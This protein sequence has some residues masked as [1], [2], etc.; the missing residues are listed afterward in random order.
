M[1][2]QFATQSL[3]AWNEADL[4]YVSVRNSGNVTATVETFARYSLGIKEAAKSLGAYQA[5]DEKITFGF[6]ELAFDPKPGDLVTPSGLSQRVVLN[7]T[8]NRMMQFW[9]L[10]VRDLVLVYDLR[11]TCSIKRPTVSAGTGGL[12]AAT[13]ADVATSVPC[14]LNWDRTAFDQDGAL[15]R[16]TGKKQYTLWL[17]QRT[18][19]QAGDIVEVSSVQYEVTEPVGF[20]IDGL[21]EIRCTRIA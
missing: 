20:G 7:A 19:T 11:D 10:M 6:D 1:S 14:K 13:F 4:G 12:R 18:E 15:G 17:G 8:P 9:D 21:A 5:Q 3:L 16:F 2:L